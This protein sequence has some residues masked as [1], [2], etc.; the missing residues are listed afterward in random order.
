MERTILFTFLWF[1]T[2][3]SQSYGINNQIQAL[4]NLYKTARS[5][6][7]AIDTCHFKPPQYVNTD[8]FVLPQECLK[9][10]DKI[11]KWPGQPPV[12]FDQYGGYVTVDEFNERAL[13]YYF[14]EAEKSKD[15]LPLLLWLNG[16]PGCSSLGYG[17]MQELGPFRVNSDGKTLHRNYY[18]WNHAANV[19]F[20]ESPAG[21]GFSYSNCS[22]YYKHCGDEATAVDNLV[23]LLNWLERF[24][25]YKSRDFYIAGE[26][27]GGHYVPELA[28]TILY[29]NKMFN[30]TIINLKGILIGNAVINHQTDESGMY[31]YFATH[32]LI[33]DETSDQIHK[34]CDFSPNV[35]HK[36]DECNDAIESADRIVFKI[37]VY[38]IYAPSCLNGNLTSIPKPMSEVIDPC[39]EYYTH[40][41]LNREDVQKAIHANVTKLDHKWAGCAGS[42]LQWNDSPSTVLPI[43]KE[44]IE[45]KIRV[46]IFSGDVDGRV[47]VTSTKWSLKKMNLTIKTPWRPWYHQGEVAGFVEVYD[48]GDLTFATVLGAGH[49]VP[50]YKS[51]NSLALVTNFLK[52]KAHN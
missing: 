40:A 22:S 5:S 48:E 7:S 37:D 17:A 33:S 49:Q 38:N 8:M 16:G 24:P 21:V 50:S 46:W 6:N 41:Y 34:Y 36:S 12:G 19:L 35:T 18:A 29:Y 13:Y 51:K 23:F 31:D 26:S 1:S 28:N 2:F 10:N 42:W 14:V 43:L 45:D 20:V 47:P 4:N 44:L 32:A 3:L 27:Y 15:S 52:G 9:E 11:H 30:K 39:S 25:E